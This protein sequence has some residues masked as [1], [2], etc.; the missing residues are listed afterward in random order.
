MALY[1]LDFADICQALSTWFSSKYLN[2]TPTFVYT[3]VV[4]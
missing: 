1:G 3:Q 2:L 4:D